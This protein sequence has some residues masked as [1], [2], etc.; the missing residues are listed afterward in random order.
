LSFPAS[1]QLD[2]FPKHIA[3]S[4]FN[5]KNSKLFCLFLMASLRF[6]YIGEVCVAKIA[7]MASLG[8]TTK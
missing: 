6:V 8:D 7:A 5:L 3:A 2:G 4:Y 1:P